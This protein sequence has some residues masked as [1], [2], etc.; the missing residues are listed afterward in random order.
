MAKR[1]EIIGNSLTIFDTDL[2]KRVTDIPRHLVYYK[3]NKLLDE[4]IISIFVVGNLVNQINVPSSILLADAVDTNDV[5]FTEDGFIAFAQENLGNDKAGTDS[6]QPVELAKN[7]L[8]YDAWGKPKVTIDNSLFHGMFTY[9]VPV[10]VWVEQLNGVEL[11]AFSNATSVNGKLNLTSGVTLSDSSYLRTFRNP[12]YEPNRGHT[13]STSVF[14]P[15]PTAAGIRR[16]G[17]FTAE[18]GS[19]YEKTATGLYGVIRTT[20]DST[21]T[22]DRYLLDER[23]IDDISKGN[24]YD[25]RMQWRGI[26]DYDFITNKF[27]SKT[28][29]LLGAATDLSMY[30]PA[31]PIAFECIN[32]GDE[33]VLQAGCVDITSE[34]GEDNGKTYGSVSISNLNGQVPVTGYNT[35]VIAIKSL[36]TVGGLINTRDTLALLVNAYSDQRSLIRVWSTRDL[37]AITLNDQVWKD[38]GDGHLQYI[39]YD[40][41]DVA[42]PMTFDTAKAELVFGSRIDQDQTYTTTAMFQN[43]TS[44]YLNPNDM[45]I[46]TIHRETGAACNVGLTFEFAEEI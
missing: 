37:T 10:T 24:L 38:F 26:G 35:P 18:S 33:V 22:D 41:P 6:P 31:N 42:T 36:G 23:Y 43:R 12:R 46:F 2:S 20:V 21:T 16:W 9:S 39:E 13:F 4:G 45:F 1:I 14:L 29:D 3:L 5:P 17:Y 44:I 11:T 25:I 30:N 15:D 34:G 40:S 19:F 7:D 28:T 32:L 8:G 27:I